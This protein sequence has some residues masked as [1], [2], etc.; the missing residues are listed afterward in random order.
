MSFPLFLDE[1]VPH[2]LAAMLTKAGCDV[3]TTSDAGRANKSLSD[4]DQLTFAA[5]DGRAI[6]TYNV[7]DFYILA[8]EWAKAGRSHMGI[9][10]S[11]QRPAWELCNRFLL[12]FQNHPDGI[13]NLCLRLP[14]LDEARGPS[15]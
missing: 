11:E 1:H 7:R 12:L 4:E 6:F 15:R 10:V 8:Q 9:I 2:D 5:E 13:P 3:L 14:T